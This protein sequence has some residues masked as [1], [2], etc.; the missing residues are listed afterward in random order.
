M[1][2]KSKIQNSTF[3]K[4][5][6]LIFKRYRPIKKIGKGAFSEIYSGINIINNEKIAIKIE[7]RYSLNKYL[8]SECYT[9]FSL[10]NIGIPKVFSF[11]HNK[12]YDILIMPLLGKSIQN[13]YISKNKNLEFKDICLMGIQIIERIQWVHSQKIIHRDIKPD[14][15]LIGLNDPNIIYLIDFGLSKK[16]RSSQTGKHIKNAEI[17]K[18]TGTVLYASANALNFREQSRR[19]DLESIG[20]MIIYLIQG[21]LP[22]MG[23]KVGN[24]KEN[25][26]KISQIKKK[27]KPEKLCENLPVELIDYMKYVK[28]LQFEETPDYGY[29]K[30]LFEKMIK[31]QGLEIENLYFSWISVS[32]FKK[33]KKPVD[34]SKRTSYSRERILNNIKKKLDSNRS[35][36]EIRKINSF[37]NCNDCSNNRVTNNIFVKRNLGD[38]FIKSN[39]KN[40]SNAKTPN[41]NYINNSINNNF[42]SI[43]V[44]LQKSINGIK[45][46]LNQKNRLKN[47]QNIKQLDIN[48][49][50][51]ENEINDAISEVNYQLNMN[52]NN[53]NKNR[54]YLEKNTHAHNKIFCYNNVKNLKSF[55]SSNRNNPA[56]YDKKYYSSEINNMNN[57]NNKFLF[58]KNNYNIN[59]KNNN[60]NLYVKKFFKLNKN[61][62]KTSNTN[63]IYNTYNLSYNNLDNIKKINKNSTV[64]FKKNCSNQNSKNIRHNN[65]KIIYN[66]LNDINESTIKKNNKILNLSPYTAKQK[67]EVQKNVNN[68]K[69]RIPNIE[70]MNEIK[71]FNDKYNNNKE[72]T[73]DKKF[74]KNRVKNVLQPRMSLNNQSADH[75]KM[76]N[77]IRSAKFNNSHSNHNNI[78]N[79]CLI[80]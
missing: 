30:F 19:D 26:L 13:I 9:L 58:E 31:K 5:Y 77:L 36:S 54:I 44:S 40:N 51:P 16:Y 33:I 55:N 76:K 60:K 28:N 12:E 45:N 29:L 63:S 65:I 52:K 23:I 10:N 11:G 34:L 42:I 47:N 48:K 46:D 38:Q 41:I 79:N 68:K 80:T 67:T 64:Y 8:E 43:S 18:F 61:S 74:V 3:I 27:I 56:L 2:T 37:S 21:S 20:Y 59:D 25:Y 24:K 7:K 4:K 71:R 1:R 22:W 17:K 15:F 75:K 62:R 70:L 69:K 66:D 32:L 39:S 53:K 73:T 50:Y 49:I 35:L 6:P 78:N 72:F 57:N 14:N